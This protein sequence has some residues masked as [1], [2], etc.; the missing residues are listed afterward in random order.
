MEL[1]QKTFWLHDRLLTTGD[2]ATLLDAMQYM[3]HFNNMINRANK[4][5]HTTE[6]IIPPEHLFRLELC[7]EARKT[8]LDY[9]IDETYRHIEELK[10][11]LKELKHYR[12]KH[13]D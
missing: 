2:K 13:Y 7:N 1:I 11:K 5:Y 3:E 4:F 10:I 8:M 12:K 6:G 9:K